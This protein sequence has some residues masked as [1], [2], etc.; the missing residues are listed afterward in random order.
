M[1]SDKKKAGS[2]KMI[3]A[4]PFFN[5]VAKVVTE[6]AEDDNRYKDFAIYL[7]K[8]F[9]KYSRVFYADNEENIIVHLYNNEA[10][11]LIKMLAI[12]VTAISNIETD[13][14]SEIAK[15]QLNIEE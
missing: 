7:K 5:T 8:K 2:V 14:Y 3:L 10:E 6:F 13:L 4:K 1:T 15:M 12:Y 9:V 11:L